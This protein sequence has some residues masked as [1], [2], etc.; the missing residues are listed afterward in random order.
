[1]KIKLFKKEDA[2]ERKISDSYSVFNFL[3]AEDSDKISVGCSQANNHNETTLINSDRAYFILEGEI[4]IN[5]NLIGKP[6][7]VIFIP[8]NTQYNFK[9][10]F[11]AAIV[12][13]PPF[14]KINEKT[15]KLQ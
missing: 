7:D 15:K 9:G 3:T 11:K 2:I 13:S 4:I 14:K 5:N 8:S 12:N 6:G 1:M 10:T